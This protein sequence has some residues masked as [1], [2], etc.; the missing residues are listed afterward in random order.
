LEKNFSQYPEIETKLKVGS[1]LKLPCEDQEII[2]VSIPAPTT[3]SANSKTKI[4]FAFWWLVFLAPI[5]LIIFW[6]KTPKRKRRLWWRR[7]FRG[8]I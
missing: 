3:P 5:P 6:L 7:V 2:P 4:I 1:V 8:K